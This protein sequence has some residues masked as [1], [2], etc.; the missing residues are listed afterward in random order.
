[1]NYCQRCLVLGGMVAL[2]LLLVNATF[3]KTVNRIVAVVNGE[4]ITMYDLQKEMGNPLLQRQNQQLQSR[5]GSAAQ[6]KKVLTSMVNHELFEQEAERLEIT[7]SDVEVENQ[8][9]QIMKERDL[10]KQE[11]E[12]TLEQSGMTMEGFEE[13]LRQDIKINRLLSSMVRQKVVVSDEEIKA[14]YE[15]HQEQYVTPKRLHIRIILHP[16][17]QKLRALKQRIEQGEISFAEAARK[18]SRG[19]G[20]EQGG[21]LG[22]VNWKDLGST[23]KEQIEPLNPGDLSRVF[24]T[25]GNAALL[26]LES[27][28]SSSSQQLSKVRDE[29]R[30]KIFSKKLK[31]RYQEYV[32]ELRSKAVLDVRL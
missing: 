18:H 30:Q 2:L 3:A 12:E 24:S 7:V 26:K 28:H 9:D 8:I 21:D 25:Q 15:K 10:S 1:M 20:A 4:I 13:K 5:Q 19:P 6:R 27:L 23:W 17:Q 11:L 16:S 14:F 32:Q 29:I 31:Q 22:L